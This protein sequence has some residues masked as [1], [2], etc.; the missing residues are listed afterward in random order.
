MEKLFFCFFL[1]S[2]PIIIKASRDPF[3]GAPISNASSTQKL[4]VE[5]ILKNLNKLAVKSIQSPDGDIIDCVDVLKQPAFDHP[6]LKD[7][8]IQMRPSSYPEGI[9]F[10]QS[11]ESS[12]SI[13]QLWQQNGTCPEGTVPIRRTREEDIL[14]ASSLQ[15][16]GKKNPKNIPMAPQVVGN[17]GH[18]YAIAYTKGDRYYGAQAHM[19]AWKP[20]VQQRDEFSISQLWVINIDDSNNLNTIEAG[21]TVNP[22]LYGDYRTRL[23][24]YWTSDSYR[25]TGCYNLL[26]SGFVQLNAGVS[27]G[28]TIW[29]L[30]FFG[31]TKSQ[32]VIKILIWKDKLNGDWWMQYGDKVMGYWPSS[33]F[34]HLSG[35]A[36]L[37]EWGGEITN[38]ESNGQH[39]RTQMGSG[40]FPSEGF[41]KASYFNNI[42]I[43][44]GNN[45]IVP[46][47]YIDPYIDNSNCYSLQTGSSHNWG[48]FIYYGGPGRNPSCP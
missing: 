11:D 14:R 21:W 15:R 31:N 41:G 1:F 18:E 29:P 42:K 23:F 47:R 37:I 38:S 48:T 17:A 26:C 30:S 44:N 5:K 46:P 34:T 39:T 40:H 6:K 33:I 27:V 10:E 12:E 22:D 3:I 36:S 2:V 8:K 9:I 7:H 32:F 43:V 13:P 24:T 16:F 35:S 25:D 19:N 20:N 45:Q 28:A 4:E